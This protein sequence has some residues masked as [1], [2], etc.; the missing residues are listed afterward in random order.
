KPA[1]LH[2]AG[3]WSW[4]SDLETGNYVPKGET[5][6]SRPRSRNVPDNICQFS[7]AVDTNEDKT[8]W[9]LQRALEDNVQS[10]PT[11]NL[12]KKDRRAWQ[13]GSE[14]YT[15]TY[16][17]SSQ[18]FIRRNRMNAHRAAEVDYPL[19]PWITEVTKGKSGYFPNPDKPKI[20]EL[21][22]DELRAISECDPPYL[23]KGDLVWMSFSAIFTIGTETWSTTFVPYEIV[24]VGAMSADLF[25]GSHSEDPAPRPQLKVGQ[26]IS[27]GQLA[28]T[29]RTITHYWL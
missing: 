11:F 20:F 3:L 24:R 23:R 18:V 22:N 2:W 19:H 17:F 26:K 21:C 29:M 4:N 16:I 25:N 14:E 15:S 10:K 5:P 9:D 13:N 12:S 28:I 6:S 27:K 7:Y 1:M 8:I